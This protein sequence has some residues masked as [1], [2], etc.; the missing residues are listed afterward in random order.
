MEWTVADRKSTS[1]EE[2][3]RVFRLGLVAA[4]SAPQEALGNSDAFFSA[5]REMPGPPERW[6][7]LQWVGRQTNDDGSPFRQRLSGEIAAM[8][9]GHP[10]PN[11]PLDGTGPRGDDPGALN[12][13]QAIPP[14]SQREPTHQANPNLIRMVLDR[15]EQEIPDGLLPVHRQAY[16]YINAIGLG[17]EAAKATTRAGSYGNNGI[18]RGAASDGA[19]LDPADKFFKALE[20]VEDPYRRV[21]AMRVT[22][23]RVELNSEFGIR[24]SNAMQATIEHAGFTGPGAAENFAFQ[25]GLRQRSSKPSQPIKPEQPQRQHTPDHVSRAA[26]DRWLQHYSTLRPINPPGVPTAEPP[27]APALVTAAPPPTSPTSA[28]TATHTHPAPEVATPGS[29][30]VA[31]NTAAT[32][33]PAGQGQPTGQSVSTAAAQPPVLTGEPAGGAGQPTDPTVTAP[34]P[35]QPPVTEAKVQPAPSPKPDGP[36]AS[37]SAMPPGAGHL[38]LVGFVP[39]LVETGKAVA[40]HRSGD[41]AKTVGE[42]VAVSGVFYLAGASVAS[43]AAPLTGVYFEHRAAQEAASTAASTGNVYGAGVHENA[44]ELFT[45]ASSAAVLAWSA[46]VTAPVTL[47]TALATGLGGALT[48]TTAYLIDTSPTFRA[49]HK[50]AVEWTADRMEEIAVFVQGDKV[51]AARRQ[52]VVNQATGG[53]PKGDGQPDYTAIQ[54]RLEAIQMGRQ[55]RAKSDS[56]ASPPAD[57][58]KLRAELTPTQAAPV[59]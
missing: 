19:A 12:Q 23:S 51:A 7:V 50:A 43:V 6:R 22:L 49:G 47:P 53:K 44:K 52:A 55:S 35:A 37:R 40:D 27:P 10:G 26:Q 41:A 20:K 29:Q 54:R 56:L 38:G 13:T 33:V 48:A 39:A 1:V 34:A 45:T 21:L 31:D 3:Q 2:Q 24:L 16:A 5:L 9:V 11:F 30:T 57:K 8:S 36:V 46:P 17:E 28:K 18:H 4:R 32:H 14:D 59:K 42:V 15:G 58:D 25:A